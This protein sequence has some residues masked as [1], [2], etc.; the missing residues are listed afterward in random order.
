MS[1]GEE[2]SDKK[3]VVLTPI[4]SSS[5]SRD[6]NLYFFKVCYCDPVELRLIKEDF[7]DYFKRKGFDVEVRDG[8]HE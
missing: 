5:T 8:W 2:M 4:L 6:G 7:K 3:V 1:V